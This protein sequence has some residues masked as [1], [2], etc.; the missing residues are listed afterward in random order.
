MFVNSKIEEESEV[1]N[2]VF[3]NSREVMLFFRDALEYLKG[4]NKIRG[5]SVL[6]STLTLFCPSKKNA[7]A[8][9][10]KKIQTFFGSFEKTIFIYSQQTLF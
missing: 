10:F 6:C 5:V 8:A 9:L 3:K 7:V 2:F 1:F 4:K